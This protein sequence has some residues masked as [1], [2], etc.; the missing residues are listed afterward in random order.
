M[1]ESMAVR[2]QLAG[3]IWAAIL[4]VAVQLVPTL[5]FAH[6][7]HGHHSGG[8]VVSTQA[9]APNTAASQTSQSSFH[10]VT[11]ASHLGQPCLPCSGGTG[12]CTGK[13]CGTG[14][15]CGAA[16]I[17]APTQALPVAGILTKISWLIVD[18]RAGIDPDGLA[19][20][21]KILV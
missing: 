14:V 19:R 18:G 21:P 1:M 12:S 2:H 9:S 8:P 16:V 5:A 11:I 3:L 6:A 17:Q 15:C 10:V 13:C 20:P 7:G 4:V